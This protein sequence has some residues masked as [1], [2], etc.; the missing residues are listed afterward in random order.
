MIDSR[1]SQT[2]KAGGLDASF[3]GTEITNGN[4]QKREY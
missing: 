1:G 3:E 2:Q 4:H